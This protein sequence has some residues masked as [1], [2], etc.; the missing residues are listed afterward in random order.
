MT[1][2]TEATDIILTITEIERSGRYDGYADGRLVVSSSCQPFLDAARALIGQ[3]YDPSRRLVMRRRPDR[4]QVDMVAPLG[5]AAGL[6][7]ESTPF[8]KPVFHRHRKAAVGA[9]SSP[10][11]RPNNT[12]DISAR[13]AA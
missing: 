6:T 2:Q 12:A 9:D 1:H 13:K 7:V 10:P 11:V 8:G 3:S 4:E 5:M